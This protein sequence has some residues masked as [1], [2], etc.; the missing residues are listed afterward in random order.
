MCVTNKQCTFN[1]CSIVF[2][3]S[4]LARLELLEQTIVNG[5]TQNTFTV[6]ISDLASGQKA[7]SVETLLDC[8]IVLYDE[9]QNSSLRR[10]KTVSEFIELRKF[11]I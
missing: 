5:A 10:E 8:L 3:V 11:F 2:S 4:P 1:S 6:S 7:L 9:C